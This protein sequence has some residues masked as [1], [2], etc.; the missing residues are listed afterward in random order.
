MCQPPR[1]RLVALFSALCF[2]VLPIVGDDLANRRAIAKSQHDLLVLLIEKGE[3]ARVPGAL[4]KIL[5][6]RFEGPQEKLVVDEILIL[7][8]MLMQRDQ[9]QMCLRLVDMGL[10]VLRRKS[11]LARLFKEK[12]MIYNRLGQSDKAM[13]MLK[14]AVALEDEAANEN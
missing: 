12:G 1:F 11:S 3:Y 14:R 5:D 13:E 7:S 2:A 9:G 8:E 10:R 4:Q 6:L